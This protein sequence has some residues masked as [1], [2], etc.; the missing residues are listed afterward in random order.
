MGLK[1]SVFDKPSF[2]YTDAQIHF[3][4]PV[5]YQVIVDRTTLTYFKT[6]VYKSFASA[7]RQ[8]K[9]ACYSNLFYTIISK[10]DA[11]IFIAKSQTVM[12]HLPIGRKIVAFGYNF[13]P[14]GGAP[15]VGYILCAFKVFVLAPV[16][17]V[18]QCLR[19]CC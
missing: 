13:C 6:K 2:F 17:T 8:S 11:E 9:S 18:P 3:K 14:Y 10:F 5:L 7:Q 19:W 16:S 1:V 4:E 15:T 12:Y